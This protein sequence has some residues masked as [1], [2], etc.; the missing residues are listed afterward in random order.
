[1]R[2]LLARAF[3]EVAADQVAVPREPESHRPHR[4]FL[5]ETDF[6][7]V[8]A[9]AERADLFVEL[10]GADFSMPGLDRV[11]PFDQPGLRDARFDAVR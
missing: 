9:A 1:M 2:Q 10:V 5:V 3:D 11:Q 6:D 8:V 7:E 4:V